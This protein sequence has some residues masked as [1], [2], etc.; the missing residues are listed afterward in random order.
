MTKIIAV[1]S[2]KGGCGKTTAAINLGL[3]LN[4]FGRQVIVVDGNLT[5]PHMSIHLGAPLVPVTLHDVLKGNA[6]IHDAAYLHPS[7]LKIIPGSIRYADLQSIDPKKLPEAV[8]GLRGKAEVVLIDASAG[9][10]SEVKAAISAA[11]AVLIVTRPELPSVTDAVRLKRL[12]KEHGKDIIGVILSHVKGDS[13]DMTTQN[14]ETLIES[15]IIGIIPYDDRMREALMLRH[16]ICYSHP[17]SPSSVAYRKVAAYL[18]GQP[19]IESIKMEKKMSRKRVTDF[20][21]EIFGV[22]EYQKQRKSK[23]RASKLL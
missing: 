7:G 14:V 16:P 5:T 18:I 21:L 17:E 13:R 15:K 22:T 1:V 3:A 12:V 4:N 6:E 19:Y 8:S 20:L 10:G 11:D 2:G 23:D 9:L